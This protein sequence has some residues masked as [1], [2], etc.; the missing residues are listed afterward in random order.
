M[1][2]LTL[3]IEWQVVRSGIPHTDRAVV[4]Y[5]GKLMAGLHYCLFTVQG[6]L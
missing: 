6:T 1:F 5:G 3:L 2:Q 4:A